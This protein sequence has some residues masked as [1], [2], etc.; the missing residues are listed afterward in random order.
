MPTACQFIKWHPFH[1]A[2]L[3]MVPIMRASMSV[4]IA[5]KIEIVHCA[6]VYM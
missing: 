3:P 1:I 2:K 6:A 5:A 4:H